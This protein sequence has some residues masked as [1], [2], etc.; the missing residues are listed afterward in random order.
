M[1]YS[2]IGVGQIVIRSIS[3]QFVL[4]LNSIHGPFEGDSCKKIVETDRRFVSPILLMCPSIFNYGHYYIFITFLF[5]FNLNIVPRNLFF[6]LF[7]K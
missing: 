3:I 1:Y 7:I 2:H 5:V 4:V 6:L